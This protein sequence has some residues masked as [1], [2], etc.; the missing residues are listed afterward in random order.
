MQ[1]AF[2]YSDRPLAFLARY[3]RRR[4]VAHAAIATAVVAAVGCSVGAQYCVKVPGE[5]VA[6][7]LM[8][9]AGILV[10]AMF[11]L[12]AAGRPLHHEFANRAAAV[13]GEMV[14]V[15]GNMPLVWSFCGIGRENRRLDATIDREMAARRRSLLY[16]EKLRLFHAAVT[17]V[18]II[19]LL[20]W[21][22]VLLPN[23]PATAGRVGLVGT[24]GLSILP[25]T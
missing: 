5:T 14:D 4:P 2:R 7:V 19:A 20:A 11:R 23:G 24:L 9:L 25:A 3:V 16:L 10:L 6:G 12:A 1:D 18:L 15:V 22:I 17:V 8:A 21:A 13:D